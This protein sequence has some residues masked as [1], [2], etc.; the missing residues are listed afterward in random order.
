MSAP[1]DVL[2]PPVGCLSGMRVSL[3]ALDELNPYE[4]PDIEAH[5]ASCARCR[6]RVAAEREAVA[7]AAE[8]PLP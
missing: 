3:A 1:F 8:E 2:E 4:R 7:R 6:A 5:L